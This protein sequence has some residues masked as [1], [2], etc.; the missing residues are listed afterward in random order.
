[1]TVIT[2]VLPAFGLSMGRSRSRSPRR[3]H[4]SRSRSPERRRERYDDQHRR[5]DR[6]RERER[7][8]PARAD[9]EAEKKA[10]RLAKLKAW[11]EQQ[12]HAALGNGVQVPPAPPAAPPTAPLFQPPA[13]APAEEDDVDPLDAFM[14]EEV[15]PEVRAREAEERARA[16]EERAKLHELLARGA[17][18]KALEELIKEEKEETPDEI[19]EVTHAGGWIF[20]V[21]SVRISLLL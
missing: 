15:L 5:A 10:A 2:S 12:A 1:M 7:G 17:L 9:P 20:G 18:P 16:A 13:A 21:G 19:M 3:Y 6:S 14:A 4:R 8:S 11:K